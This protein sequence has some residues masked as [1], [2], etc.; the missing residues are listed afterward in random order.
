MSENTTSC[1]L[2]RRALQEA[3]KIAGDDD[4]RVGGFFT[5]TYVGDGEQKARGFNPPKLYKYVY[6][7]PSPTAGLIQQQT[8]QQAT[9]PAVQAVP[10]PAQP[11]APADPAAAMAQ[12][13]TFIG[14]G[15]TDQQIAAAVPGVDPAA[16]AAIR[17]LPAA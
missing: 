16:I 7:K 6:A 8:Q 11:T 1:G 12:I 3:V 13:Q 15:M 17:A 9:P 14:L 4:I 5:A 10:E 2:Q